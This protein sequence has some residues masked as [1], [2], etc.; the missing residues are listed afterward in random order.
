MRQ[1][2]AE[3]FTGEITYVTQQ[4]LPRTIK[5]CHILTAQLNHTRLHATLLDQ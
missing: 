1:W 3:N 2:P 4:C 5:I